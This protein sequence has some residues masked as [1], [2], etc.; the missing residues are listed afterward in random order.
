MIKYRFF[1]PDQDLSPG[2]ATITDESK[3]HQILKVLRLRIGDRLMLLDNQGYESLGQIESLEPLKVKI[4]SHEFNQNEPVEQI[5]LYQA[6]IKKDKFEWVLQKG[7]EVGISQFVPVLAARSEKKDIGREERL[8]AILTEA[9]EQS[10]RGRI[11]VLRPE[12]DFEDIGSPEKQALNLILDPSAQVPLARYFP[13][14]PAYK[15]INLL[16]GPEGGFA[17]EELTLAQS[18]GWEGVNLGPRIL[19]TE[20]AGV[21][22]AGAILIATQV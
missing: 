18:K 2:V 5:V 4:L 22:A 14:V 17:P 6:L 8:L 19:R 3:I 10:A 9:A 7:T 16:V 13:S 1:L 11:P 20:T 21:L 15:K 12:I